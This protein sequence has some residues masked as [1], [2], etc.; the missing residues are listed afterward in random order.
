[1]AGGDVVIRFGYPREFGVEHLFA[2]NDFGGEE[3]AEKGVGGRAGEFKHRWVLF[4]DKGGCLIVRESAVLLLKFVQGEAN[5][6][7]VGYGFGS[8]SLGPIRWQYMHEIAE[9]HYTSNQQ[10][11][12]WPAEGF[13]FFGFSV[14]GDL[15][16]FGEPRQVGAYS[17][18]RISG[19]LPFQMG[20]S[21]ERMLIP[22]L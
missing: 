11:P 10:E 13:V 2:F 17:G 16:I 4:Y 15:E 21:G 8:V 6:V 1:M 22:L 3:L 18:Y 9:N 7:E 19:A 5:L 12:K 14:H 20:Y